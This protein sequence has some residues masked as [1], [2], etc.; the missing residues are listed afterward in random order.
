MNKYVPVVQ[1][2]VKKRRYKNTTVIYRPHFVRN[3][4]SCVTV[5]VELLL[6]PLRLRSVSLNER[7]L[8]SN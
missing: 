5:C 2:N 1:R 3:T 8:L 6:C 7:L 4:V